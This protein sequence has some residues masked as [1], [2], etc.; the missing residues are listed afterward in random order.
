MRRR[1][2]LRNRR[3]QI[4][5]MII[6]GAGIA[7]AMASGYFRTHKPVVYEKEPS[8]EKRDSNHQAV[9][10]LRSPEIGFLLGCPLDK[11]RVERS[12]FSEGQHHSKTNLRLSN[13]YSVKVSGC[14]LDRSILSV[15]DPSERFLLRS[16]I[17]LD[18]VIYDAKAEHIEDRKIRFMLGDGRVAEEEYDVCI[19][20]IP[21]PFLLDI[22]CFSEELKSLKDTFS[23]RTSPVYILRGQVLIPSKVVQ[24]VYYPDLDTPVYRATI[25]MQTIIIE[26]FG[27]W[28][29]EDDISMVLRS[30][31]LSK[32]VGNEVSSLKSYMQNYGKISPIDE[33]VRKA[34]I[35][36]AT[37]KHR[38]FSLGRYAIWK[39]LTSDEVLPDL[40]KIE[41]MM[42]LSIS[43]VR[44]HQRR[45]RA[46]E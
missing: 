45:E 32:G 38:I 4:L 11:V 21:M 6:L 34:I 13:S 7:G 30:F 1:N 2:L 19:S 35:Y 29:S 9:F 39:N 46:S 41:Q 16:G 3:E 8:K 10:R 18:R 40:R 24:T 22:G 26:S 33:D 31:G 23:V 25:E 20:T 15:G 44:Y 14:L 12:I 43:S 17:H 37:E 27:K 36:E 42:R 28:P 5:K